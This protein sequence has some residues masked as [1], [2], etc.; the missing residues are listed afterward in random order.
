M[1]RLAVAVGLAWLLLPLKT[2][3]A[4]AATI[5]M[6]SGEIMEGTILSETDA[7]IRLQMANENRT[8]IF[9]RVLQ[10]SDV[11]SIVRDTPE[12]EA[13]QAAYCALDKYKL[14]P[15]QELTA[16]QYKQGIDAFEKFLSD[17]PNSSH[18]EEIRGKLADWKAEAA[19]LESGKVKFA[20]RWMLPAEKNLLSL[21]Q[22]Q[23]QRLQSLQQQRENKLQSIQQQLADL[24]TQRDSLAVSI[25]GAEGRLAGLH[26]KLKTLPRQIREPIYSGSRFTG[27]YVTVPNPDVAKVQADIISSEQSIAEGRATVRILDAKIQGLRAQIPQSTSTTAATDLVRSNPS[28]NLLNEDQRLVAQ[29]TDRKFAGSLDEYSTKTLSALRE[30]AFDRRE[31]DNHDRWRSV[32]ALGL[33]GDKQS[34]PELIYLLYHYN[35][36]TRWWAQIS[37]VRLTGQNFGKDWKAWGKWWTSQNGQPPFDPEI[38]R[39]SSTQA[40]PDK[41]AESLDENDGRF[42]AHLRS[43]GASS[44]GEPLPAEGSRPSVNSDLPSAFAN[45]PPASAEELRSLLESALK[46]KEKNVVLSLFNQQGVSKDMKSIGDFIVADMCNH[47]IAAV[48]L[49]GLPADFQ[50]TNEL[51]GVRYLL[52]VAAVGMMDV[53]YTEKG[54]AVKMPYGTKDGVFYLA[55]T[56]EEKTALPAIRAKSINVL[57]M[58]SAMPDAGTFAGSYVYVKNGK[59]IKEDLSGKGNISKAFWGDSIKSCIV[60]KNSDSPDWIQLIIS[61]DGQEIFKSERVSARTSIVWERK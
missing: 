49:S 7:E 45:K 12:Q 37:L 50:P 9:T 28:G 34:V 39:W 59:E 44:S 61:E 21:Q 35:V 30:M 43:T 18:V 1:K 4:F 10:K 46:A 14:Y 24:Q 5:T 25:A 53:E 32:R 15:S 8:I 51:N 27:K 31:R 17:H 20:G 48:K 3:V 47:N 11:K 19:N 23:E 16:A 22:Q 58:G 2:P 55:S 26:T 13:Q 56:I 54:N 29:W 40:E 6:N 41:L 52:N 33:L 60:Q 38:I 36:N 57:V 42:L